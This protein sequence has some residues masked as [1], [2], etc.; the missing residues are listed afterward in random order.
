MNPHQCC[1]SFFTPLATKPPVRTATDVTPITDL[2]RHSHSSRSSLFFFD[3]PAFAKVLHTPPAP[4]KSTCNR[5][6]ALVTLVL[7]FVFRSLSLFFFFLEFF[8]IIISFSA[9]F[10]TGAVTLRSV[11]RRT[12]TPTHPRTSHIIFQKQ[13]HTRSAMECSVASGLRLC[14]KMHYHSVGGKKAK[15]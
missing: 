15:R 9:C 11:H 3:V 4:V 10:S 1:D 14:I 7:Q 12:H 13:T 5:L 2:V 6:C 8:K